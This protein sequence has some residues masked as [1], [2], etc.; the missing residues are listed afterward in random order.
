MHCHNDF[1]AETGMFMQLVE[2]PAALRQI[3]GTWSQGAIDP[4]ICSVPG[5][6]SIGPTLSWNGTNTMNF[7]KQYPTSGKVW[8]PFE[9]TIRESMQYYGAPESCYNYNAEASIV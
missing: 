8:A 9:Q 6:T 3:I 5:G 2:A 1:H 7:T 4:N